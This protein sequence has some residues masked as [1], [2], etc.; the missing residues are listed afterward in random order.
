[1]KPWSRRPRPECLHSTGTHG[2]DCNRMSGSGV[3]QIG[4]KHGRDN[5]HQRHIVRGKQYS[6]VRMS[7]QAIFL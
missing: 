7:Q 4:I 1:M 2:L 6:S 3:A 5:P